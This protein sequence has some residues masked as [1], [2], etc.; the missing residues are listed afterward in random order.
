MAGKG[1][2]LAT[3]LNENVSLFFPHFV[4]GTVTQCVS[5]SINFVLAGTAGLFH[6]VVENSF[7]TKKSLELIFGRIIGEM[8]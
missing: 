8:V 3:P 1:E 7:F 4:T 6:S 2:C 5:K